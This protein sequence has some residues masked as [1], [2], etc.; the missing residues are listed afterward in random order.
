MTELGDREINF[1]D[2]P[3]NHRY[4]VLVEGEVAGKAVYH[5]R[6]DRYLFVH[7][8]VS[9]DYSGLGLATKLVHYSLEDLRS[10]HG[11]L[12]PI[13]PFYL[14]YLKRNPGYDDLVD[15]EMLDRINSSK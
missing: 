13:C 14:A 1:R 3:D 4:V 9:D 8:E 5:L 15:H 12:V 11:R 10:R 6:G 2:E 7:T